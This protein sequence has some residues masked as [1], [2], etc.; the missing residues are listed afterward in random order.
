MGNSGSR[1]TGAPPS[2]SSAP[3]SA[4]AKVG[5][6]S[7]PMPPMATVRSACAG[8][9]IS[10]TDTVG[11]SFG[12]II[13]LVLKLRRC[14][15]PL[16]NTCSPYSVALMACTTPPISCASAFSGFTVR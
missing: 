3:A 11:I 12:R 13:R 1:R 6:P 9:G 14:A 16:T 10:V 8:G 5:T 15:T 2:F 4:G 7:S